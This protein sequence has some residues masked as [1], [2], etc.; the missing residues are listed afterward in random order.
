MTTDEYNGQYPDGW[1]QSDIEDYEFSG[2]TPDD[3]D[4]PDGYEASEDGESFDLN[5]EQESFDLNWQ[6]LQGSKH[7]IL[8]A[9]LENVL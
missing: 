2:V 5:F 9:N 3:G 4:M 8:F 1:S 7:P 6:F